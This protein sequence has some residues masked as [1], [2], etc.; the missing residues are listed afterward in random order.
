MYDVPESITIIHTAPP[1]AWIVP[2]DDEIDLVGANFRICVRRSRMVQLSAVVADFLTPDCKEFPINLELNQAFFEDIFGYLVAGVS[3]HL[4][5]PFMKITDVVLFA[6]YM[7]MD[8]LIKLAAFCIRCGVLEFIYHQEYLP[9]MLY[10]STIMDKQSSNMDSDD[11]EG[12][13]SFA[14]WTRALPP[15][16][17]HKNIPARLLEKVFPYDASDAVRINML[18]EWAP[19]NIDYIPEEAS[20]KMIRTISWCEWFEVA[21]CTMNP[22]LLRFYFDKTLEV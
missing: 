8:E 1:V 2:N 5:V 14:S 3:P 11:D 7:Q 4:C 18:R 10:L 22:D 17:T 13:S 12:N 6:D 19:K 20:I 9:S 16:F 15:T 21:F